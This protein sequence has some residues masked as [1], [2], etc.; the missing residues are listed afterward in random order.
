M[1][2]IKI[3]QITIGS[4]RRKLADISE[5]AASIKELGL[6]NAVQVNEEFSLIAGLHRV[7][8]CRSLGWTEIDAIVLSVNE[9]KAEKIEIAE[10]LFRVDLIV[11]E[12]GQQLKRWIEL[13]DAENRKTEQIVVEE[14]IKSKTSN[15]KP[16][17]VPINS[18]PF[19]KEIAEKTAKSEASVYQ[20]VQ[21]ATRIPEKVQTLIKDLPVADN[22]SDL[23]K[24]S[25]L[26]E[27]AQGEIAVV[28]SKKK[29]ES[30]DD[31]IRVLDKNLRANEPKLN[32][33]QKT[34]SA[35]DGLTDKMFS[36]LIS[37][38]SEE[39]I[40]LSIDNLTERQRQAHYGSAVKLRDKLNEWIEIYEKKGVKIKKEGEL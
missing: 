26:N 17:I 9:I 36:F 7:E 4:S 12:R 27:H 23:L 38:Q 8:A 30:V 34:R 6:I 35:W 19:V 40:E 2:K 37:A 14:K 1:N 28:L 5:L 16:I 13:R 18:R 32:N 21:I 39:T 33:H 22:K 10:N 11:L 3:E 20:D 15:S 25:R 31:A 24:L 29:V